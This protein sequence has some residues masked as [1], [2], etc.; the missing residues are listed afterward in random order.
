MNSLKDFFFK[1]G[2][3]GR[4]FII[5]FKWCKSNTGVSQGLISIMNGSVGICCF[6]KT[7]PHSSRTY[8]SKP[9]SPSPWDFK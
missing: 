3:F 9:S 4:G 6:A 8:S 5:R 7:L 1:Q 2:A